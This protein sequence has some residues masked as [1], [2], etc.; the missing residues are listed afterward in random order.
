MDSLCLVCPHRDTLHVRHDPAFQAECTV[1][2]WAPL[3][4]VGE[5]DHATIGFCACVDWMKWKLSPG[6]IKQL[7]SAA[8]AAEEGPVTELGK[9]VE[10]DRVFS[11]KLD[12]EERSREAAKE[13]G[14]H[15]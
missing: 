6:G 9:Q 11:E 2:P 3:Y 8:E 13:C 7:S 10:G 5:Q 4:I 1:C 15:L 12:V 14:R